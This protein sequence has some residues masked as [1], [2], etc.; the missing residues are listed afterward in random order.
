VAVLVDELDS[1]G[2]GVP[3]SH[4]GM[5]V[6]E[7]KTAH[8]LPLVLFSCSARVLAVP[9]TQLNARRC[10]VHNRTDR[11]LFEVLPAAKCGPCV[12]FGARTIG[13]MD[14]IWQP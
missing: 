5:V 9:V 2:Y 14:R 7:V 11:V 1:P 3:D 12:L 10:G 4:A 8:A 13:H 6:V